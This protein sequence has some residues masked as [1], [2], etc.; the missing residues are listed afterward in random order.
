MERLG[1]FSRMS[2][3]FFYTLWCLEGR[4]ETTCVTLKPDRL[5]LVQRVN[6]DEVF[7]AFK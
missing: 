4:N 1:I 3:R 7:F 6:K 5:R 2:K